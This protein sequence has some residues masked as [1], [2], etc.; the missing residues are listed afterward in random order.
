M[1]PRSPV[2][3]TQANMLPKISKDPARW[4][5]PLGCGKFY[6][7]NSSRSIQRHRSRCFSTFLVSKKVIENH[8]LRQEITFNPSIQW[9]KSKKKHKDQP[10]GPPSATIVHYFCIASS[11]DGSIL[12]KFKSKLCK[13]DESKLQLQSS[14]IAQHAVKAKSQKVKMMACNSE[15]MYYHQSEEYC[16]RLLTFIVAVQSNYIGDPPAQ[17]ISDFKKTYLTKQQ[18]AATNRPMATSPEL[19]MSPQ[20]SPE[21]R[22][23]Q[24]V[25]AVE[26]NAL[27]ANQTNAMRGSHPVAQKLLDGKAVAAHQK[28]LESPLR[29]RRPS[30]ITGT[31]AHMIRAP[32]VPFSS[33]GFG[34]LD[35][36]NHRKRVRASFDNPR[37]EGKLSSDDRIFVY[38]GGFDA[39]N[40]IK[41]VRRRLDLSE[42]CYAE[43]VPTERMLHDSRTPPQT[44][45]SL[46]ALVEVASRYQR[47]PVHERKTHGEALEL[48]EHWGKGQDGGWNMHQRTPSVRQNQSHRWHNYGRRSWSLKVEMEREKEEER[49]AKF[50]RIAAGKETARRKWYEVTALGRQSLGLSREKI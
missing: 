5:C 35:S 20:Y 30:P 15:M 16:G 23:V 14:R 8:G 47:Y 28:Q 10:D 37:D 4:Q 40:R 7:K 27:N 44:T 24:L 36:A 32:N 29:P 25:N 13:V 17:V 21:F 11:P 3:A 12:A 48:T 43:P 34:D 42:Q 26:E 1:L 38:R 31:T 22:Q 18:E 39:Q 41:V 46:S 50:M 6:K 9:G 45:G 49:Y 33:P 2:K 19:A